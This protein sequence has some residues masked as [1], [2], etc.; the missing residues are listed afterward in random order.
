MKEF[1]SVP[2]HRH[3]ENEAPRDIHRKGTAN[4]TT[5]RIIQQVVFRVSHVPLGVSSGG[6]ET[7][8]DCCNLILLVRGR[9]LLVWWYKRYFV[10]L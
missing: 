6:M 10:K 2:Q 4:S 1:Q 9:F 7:K 3:G 5:S 8:M